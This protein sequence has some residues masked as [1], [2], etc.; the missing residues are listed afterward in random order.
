MSFPVIGSKSVWADWAGF[1]I[2]SWN[3]WFMAPYGVWVYSGFVKNNIAYF[4]K[5]NI[6]TPSTN[7]PMSDWLFELATSSPEDVF[8]N[9]RHEGYPNGAMGCGVIRE[10]AGVAK[11]YLIGR[12]SPSPVVD[13]VMYRFTVDDGFEQEA[14]AFIPLNQIAGS[15]LNINHICAIEVDPGNAIYI[16]T[17]NRDSNQFKIRK[18]PYTFAGNADPTETKILSPSFMENNTSARIR[19]MGQARDGSIIVFVN[20]GITTT[21]CKVIK[22]DEVDLDYRGQTTWAPDITTATWAYIV[23]TADVF[24]Y[25]EGLDSTSALGAKTAVYYDN[26]TGIPS[27]NKSNFIIDNN[28]TQ[29]GSDTAIEL[30]YH[31]RDAFNVPVPGVNTKFVLTGEDPNDP[32]SWNDRVAGIQDA[33]GNPFFDGGGVPLAIQAIV[34]TNGSGIALAYYKPMR[35]G[36][37][38]ETDNI[39]IFCPSDN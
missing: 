5:I 38:T 26:A 20:T 1:G 13:S 9:E 3:M 30:A 18:Y 17:N 8:T 14:G 35:T 37:G 22:L 25:F 39:S 11:L 21:Q 19:G 23:P 33:P 7:Y 34:P 29:Y 28:L 12:S 10:N 36:S 24:M 15:P 27:E 4:K 31:A 32:S 16:A 6:G 2:G